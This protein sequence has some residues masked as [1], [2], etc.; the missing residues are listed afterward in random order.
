MSL[1][2]RAF[3][4]SPAAVLSSP[5][6]AFVTNVSSASSVKSDSMPSSFTAVTA[7]L[8]FVPTLRPVS[9]YSVSSTGES[10]SL[11]PSRY[12]LYPFTAALVR[13]TSQE[14]IAVV[15]SISDTFTLIGAAGVSGAGFSLSDV[16]NVAASD[17]ADSLPA[18]STAL[19]LT[20]Y[21]VASVSPV[22]TNSVPA[23]SSSF[24][25]AS[26]TYTLYPATPTLSVD[27][28]Q[29][30]FAPVC[31]T[32]VADTFVGTLG[33]AV[34]FSSSALDVV[35]V[36]AS[37]PADSLPAASTALTLT[38]YP[39]LA[40]S[41][42]NT[43]SVA[44]TGVSFTFPSPTYTL[45]PTTPSL[46]VD[47]LQVTFAP[48]C[49]TSVTDTFVGTLG[50]SVSTV[51][52]VVNVAAVDLPDSLP[53]A[54]TAVTLTVYPVASV[55]SDNAYSVPVTSA[56]F[57]FVSFTYTLY[58]TTPT[59][60][61]ASLQV[62]FA[63]VCVTSVAFTSFGAVGASVS[64]LAAVVNTTASDFADSFSA[65]ST[66]VTV[67]L[68][69]VAAVRSVKLYSVPVTSASFTFVSFT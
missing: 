5:L 26:F 2:F 29:V 14:T 41:P 68:Y 45:Y 19:T 28:L 6:S 27:A 46:S 12:T 62:T 1:S 42:V 21:S 43:Y 55:S 11:S 63:V 66:A 59:L 60:S 49:V 50:A 51:V 53:A 52:R 9:L 24:T 18:A 47:A 8:Y 17:L 10:F 58:P 65:A 13:A 25:F 54:S 23:T 64:F 48:V 7:T 30:T 4:A 67:T 56:S 33:T 31:V 34:S 38:V 36:A 32:S 3:S 61:V 35:N 40:V 15:W 16:V 37:D 44:V 69:S 57:T 39:V 20:V 22:S